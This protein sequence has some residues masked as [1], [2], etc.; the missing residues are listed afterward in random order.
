MHILRL[1]TFQKVLEDLLLQIYVLIYHPM[2]HLRKYL[3][4]LVLILIDFLGLL[5]QFGQQS[6]R[7]LSLHVLFLLT[8]HHLKY[9][10]LC[11]S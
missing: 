7:N 10:H 11:L 6:I 5:L 8:T 1:S 4:Q 3:F 2:R 9:L